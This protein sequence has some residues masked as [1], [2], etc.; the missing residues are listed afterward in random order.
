MT[1]SAA[2]PTVLLVAADPGPADPWAEYLRLI[3]WQVEV[4]PDALSALT[5]LE[6]LDPHAV[7]CGTAPG[8]LS[9]MDLLDIVRSDPQHA[10]L[11]FV[12]LGEGSGHPQGANDYLLPAD[13]SAAQLAQTLWPL[14]GAASALSA[15][16]PL[17]GNLETLGLSGV[18]E[19]LG[20]GER[21][22]TLRL[23]LLFSESTLHLVAGQIVQASFGLSEGEEAALTL[24][25]G[26]QQLLNLDYTFEAGAPPAVPVITASTS[27]LLARAA[28]EWPEELSTSELNSSSEEK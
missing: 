26:A 25:R 20:Q 3:G 2:Q 4:A 10:A 13:V 28:E 7:V 1:L 6:R 27:S 11:T 16:P 9:G 15:A 18:L 17:S 24:L 19:A 22:G 8:S 5:Q 23:R 12:L 21:S 14:P